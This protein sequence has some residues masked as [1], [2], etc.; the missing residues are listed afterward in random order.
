MASLTH[1][2]A[3]ALGAALIVGAFGVLIWGVFRI[4]AKDHDDPTHWVT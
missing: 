4:K 1:L 3:A 2:V